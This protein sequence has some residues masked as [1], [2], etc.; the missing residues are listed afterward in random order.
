MPPVNVGPLVN[1]PE[2]NQD[3]F[4]SRDERFLIFTSVNRK[5][6]YGSGDLYF[7]VKDKNKN[8]SVAVN[9]GKRFNTGSFDFCSAVTPDLKYFFFSSE[10]NVKWVDAKYLPFDVNKP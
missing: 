10:G 2:I 7:S 1:S 6:G 4:I 5:D 8:W 9:M 3:P